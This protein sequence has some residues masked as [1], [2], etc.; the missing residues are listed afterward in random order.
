MLDASEVVAGKNWLKST[1]LG[2]KLLPFVVYLYNLTQANVAN[3]SSF[4][5]FM[6]LGSLCCFQVNQQ[7]MRNKAIQFH[8]F[9]RGKGK[10]LQT[11]VFMEIKKKWNE[12][13][14]I[15]KELHFQDI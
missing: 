11:S 10:L 7:G 14:L 1:V 9:P 15:N 8:F 13:I 4:N 6:C 2:K 5:L 3:F 12:L